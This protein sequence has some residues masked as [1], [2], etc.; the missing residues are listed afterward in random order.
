MLY[1]LLFFFLQN[2][3]VAEPA[4]IPVEKDS[5][6]VYIFMSEECPI[7]RY[8]VHDINRLSNEYA[9]EQINFIGV[10]PNFS[11]KKEKIEAFTKDYKLDIP[12]QTDYFKSLAKKLDAKLT[13]EVFV[14]N[15]D[16]KVLYRGRIDNAYV[17]L[18]NRRRV[19]TNHDLEK[20][21]LNL[22]KGDI[23]YTQTESIG[24]Y[25]HYSDFK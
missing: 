5:Y 13:P 1:F 21:L 25:I 22:Q 6:T 7:C 18:G 24:C 20:F 2:S 16:E 19:V 15:Q 14:V 10:F 11:S 17:S 23:N 8:Y 4:V 3:V 9:S 12:T